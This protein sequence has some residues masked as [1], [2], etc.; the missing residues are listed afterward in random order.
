MHTATIVTESG[1]AWWLCPNCRQK[2][3][4]IIGSRV[5]IVARERR[6]FIAATHESDQVCWRCGVPSALIEERN[7]A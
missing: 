4:E 6:I 1:D 5:V 7:I 2:L 3:A